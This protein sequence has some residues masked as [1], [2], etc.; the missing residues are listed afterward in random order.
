MKA[1]RPIAIIGGGFSGLTLAWYLTKLGLPVE[2]FEASHRCGGLIASRQEKI[3]V[4]S[5]ANAI[6]SHAAVE[7]LFSELELSAVVA[8]YRSKKRY[9][10]TDRLRQWPVSAVGTASG[11]VKFF[12]SF[13]TGKIKPSD[14]ESVQQWIE[15]ILNPEFSLRLVSPALQGIYGVG[16]EKLSAQLIWQSVKSKTFKA[17]KGRKRGSIAPREGMEQIIKQLQLKLEEKSV[18]FHFMT[19]PEL[20]EIQKKYSQLVLA[21]PVA[22]AARLTADFAPRFS[23]L[24]AMVPT[25]GLASV[26]L[27]FKK[28]K[29]LKGFGCLFSAA[30]GAQKMQSLGVLFNTDI[31]PN[32]GE[33]QSETWILNRSL[34]KPEEAVSMVLQDRKILLSTQENPEQVS[35]SHW[36]EALPLYG[37]E[38]RNALTSDFFKLG[39]KLPESQYPIYLTGNYLG[40][41]G[42]AK[43]LAYNRRLAEKIK[44]EHEVFNS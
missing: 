18:R 20:S 43:I 29:K 1:T 32:R 7:E 14:S 28:E 5:A 8:G 31:F 38:L 17:A 33:L 25:Q 24:L 9:I 13:I 35:V 16:A 34:T 40:G 26:T 10:L 4:E 30:P 27:G 37:F 22:E 44:D 15:R 23:T 3:L 19:R 36:P 41:I 2:V 39:E 21:V 42:L 11:I 6:L 12:C